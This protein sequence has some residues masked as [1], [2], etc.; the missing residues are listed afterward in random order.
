VWRLPVLKAEPCVQLI[1]EVERFCARR[2]INPANL[3]AFRLGLR[4]MLDGLAAGCALACSLAVLL[5]IVCI[6]CSAPRCLH[7]VCI[8][9]CRYLNPVI[10][11]LYPAHKFPTL[12][13]CVLGTVGCAKACVR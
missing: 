2:K 11:A 7:F 6:L 8:G 4:P 3:D 12:K 10:G 5:C 13:V 9:C 1:D